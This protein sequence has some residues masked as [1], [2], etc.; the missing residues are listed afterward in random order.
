MIFPELENSLA[1]MTATLKKNGGIYDTELAGFSLLKLFKEFRTVIVQ[2]A[3]VLMQ[4]E[5]YLSHPVFKH[6]I[7]QTSLFKLYSAD[8]E[9]HLQNQID[10]SSD[11][12]N[13]HAPIIADRLDILINQASSGKS[14]ISNILLKQN[15]F[16]S[17]I[18]ESA[19][20]HKTEVI[21]MF[22][23]LD[24]DTYKIGVF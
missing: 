13:L 8:L 11:S 1:T 16:P 3:A 14:D 19:S 4:D 17:I 22:L 2:D 23:L 21:V 9:L 5:Q 6:S 18:E 12:L 10:P 15:E 7:F 20:I 24:C